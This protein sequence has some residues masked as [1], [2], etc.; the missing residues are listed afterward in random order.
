MSF[1]NFLKDIY[2]ERH[3]QQKRIHTYYLM[4]VQK[5]DCKVISSIFLY[6]LLDFK[7]NVEIGKYHKELDILKEL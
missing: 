4:F 5:R 3:V 1:M 6:R 2:E 7:G